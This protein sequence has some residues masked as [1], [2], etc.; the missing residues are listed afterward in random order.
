MLF[1]IFFSLKNIKNK[2]HYT[3]SNI[4]II[5][6]NKLFNIPIDRQCELR[7]HRYRKRSCE[8]LPLPTL[9]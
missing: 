1:L 9:N 4:F 5:K 2:I 7:A 6:G 3:K 8:F